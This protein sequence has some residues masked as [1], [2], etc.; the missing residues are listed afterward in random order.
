MGKAFRNE[1]TTKSFIYRTC[2][3]EQME[4]QFFVH[5]SEDERWFGEWKAARMQYY[6]DMG[7][8]PEKLRFHQH[9][10]DEIAFYAKDAYDIEYEFPFGWGELEGIHNRTDHDLSRHA[11]FSGKEQSVLNEETRERFVPYIIE[12]AVGLTRTVL[13]VLSDAYDE[14]QV[15]EETRSVMR[16]HPLIAPVT[17]GIFPLVKKDGLSEIA[18]EIEG[19]LRD[20]YSVYYDQGGAIGRRYRRQ[21][22]VGTP[23][24]VTVD[25]QTKDDGT[26]TVRDRDT[27]EQNRVARSE[28][29]E[30]IRQAIRGYRR[31]GT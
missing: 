5:P 29:T 1:I 8:R 20:A 21:D 7:I 28:L 13:M 31:M 15:G 2:E 10:P 18:H 3:F 24:C 6:I 27:M 17:V 4:M 25:Y 12:T 26:V 16:F 19:D 9:G 30:Y 11:E 14:E 22:E 23:F